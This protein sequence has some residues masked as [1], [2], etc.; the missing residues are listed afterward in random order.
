MHHIPEINPLEGLS[1]KLTS[2]S[3]K[4]HSIND[5]DVFTKMCTQGGIK[6][7]LN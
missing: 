7:T 5:E 1:C 6:W 3:D 2:I 4:M